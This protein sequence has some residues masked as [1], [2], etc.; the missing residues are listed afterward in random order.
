MTIMQIIL[1]GATLLGGITSIWFF[2]E[3]RRLI[4]A[5][6]TRKTPVP[7]NPLSLVD[8]DY[9]FLHSRSRPLLQGAYL[10]TGDAEETACK[11]LTNAGV[12]VKS[13]GR[14][15]LSLAGRVMLNG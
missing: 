8:E 15:R 1:A 13:R 6:F 3:K 5:W 12:L 9:T 4:K 7:I 11:S 2:C 14:Y 10:P